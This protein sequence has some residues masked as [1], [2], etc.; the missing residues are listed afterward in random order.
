MPLMPKRVK[1]RKYQRGSLKGKAS[2]GNRVVFGEFGL[3]AM[4]RGRL[5]AEQ[6]EAGRLAVMHYLRR[7][8]KLITRV[9]PHESITTTPTETRMGKGK[10]EVSHWIAKVKPGTII[11]ELS[12]VSEEL[13][14]AA[15]GRVAHKLPIR[16]KL[17]YRRAHA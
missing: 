17:A 9:F 5:T 16:T 13:A 6:L 15:L 10:G 7:E 2:R 1:H 14:V 8:G 12:G 11:F 4:E 3:R